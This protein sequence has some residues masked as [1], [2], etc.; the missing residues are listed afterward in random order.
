MAA[1]LNI[2]VSVHTAQ[3]HDLVAIITWL[4]LFGVW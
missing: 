4:L 1:G 2:D 3:H